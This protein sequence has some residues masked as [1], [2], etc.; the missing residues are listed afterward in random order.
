MPE[1]LGSM[2]GRCCI[3]GAEQVV[4]VEDAGIASR[5]GNEHAS[6]EAARRDSK[7]GWKIR[8]SCNSLSIFESDSGGTLL[9]L[10]S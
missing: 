4:G 3:H 10:T 6:I 1:D 8:N 7:Q 2:E 5:C 9:K